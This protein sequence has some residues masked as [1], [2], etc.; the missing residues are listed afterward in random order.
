MCKM[1]YCAVTSLLISMDEELLTILNNKVV[2]VRTTG[3]GC[4]CNYILDNNMLIYV[5][6]CMS[7]CCFCKPTN[8]NDLSMI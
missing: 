3:G 1:T 2:W 8:D 7:I 5:L 6:D 4:M